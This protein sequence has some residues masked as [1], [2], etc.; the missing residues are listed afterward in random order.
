M[1]RFRRPTPTIRL[2]LT[3][4]YGGLFLASG[5]SLL[6]ITYFLL[7]REYTG[8]FFVNS[9]KLMDFAVPGFLP[10]GEARAHLEALFPQAAAAG[11]AQSAAALHELLVGSGIALAVMAVLSIWLGWLIA[12]RTLRPL[13]TITN[14]AR[15]ISATSLHRRLALAGPEDE[16]KQLGTTFDD[17]LERLEHAFESQRQFVANASHELRTPLTFQ[18]TLL[19]VALGE[20]DIDAET[21]ETYQELLAVGEE[22]EEL[23]DALLTLSQSQRGL[24]VHEPVDLAAIAATVAASCERDGLVFET[25]FEPARTIGDPRLIERLV[26]NLISNAICHNN[27]GGHVTVETRQRAGHAI[28]CVRNSGEQISAED[29]TRLFQPF[30]RLARDRQG[31]GGFGLGLSIVYA[32]AKAHDASLNAS[33]GL[34]GGLDIEVGF[35]A[36]EC[37]RVSGSD[38]AAVTSG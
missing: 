6:A 22:Q 27:P 13:R 9:G 38:P 33:P 4:I 12:G 1:S 14:T 18:R 10:K 23:I 17:L 25:D 34:D 20:P 2:R 36:G 37:A 19:E 8:K 24:D 29:V 21:R 3:A 16:L 26:A 7:R 15:E 31:S 11:R 5:A 28:L 30:E 35:P 32:I